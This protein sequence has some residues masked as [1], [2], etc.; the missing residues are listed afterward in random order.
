MS[1]SDDVDAARRAVN[2]TLFDDACLRN[3]SKCPNCD[4]LAAKLGDVEFLVHGVGV[5]AGVGS[6]LAAAGAGATTYNNA[7]NGTTTT[8]MATTQQADAA[9]ERYLQLA[10][11]Y[12]HYKARSEAEVPEPEWTRSG[13]LFFAF[14][15][16]TAIG[17]GS[18][19]PVTNQAKLLITILAIPGIA[20]FGLCL[21]QLAHILVALIE[22]TRAEL[23]LVFGLKRYRSSGSKSATDSVGDWPKVVMRFDTNR[24]GLLSLEEVLHAGGDA[25][26]LFTHGGQQHVFAQRS[27]LDP[28]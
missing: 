8:T 5:G 23:S 25:S 2:P 4:R 1:A 17:F 21:S 12:I 26:I 27:R 22:I 14:T 20:V 11:L 9:G 7:N 16:L 3:S 6:E 10:E 13:S 19:A 18:P 15:T 24:D 28:R